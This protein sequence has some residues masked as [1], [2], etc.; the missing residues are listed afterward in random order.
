MFNSISLY[1]RAIFSVVEALGQ[2]PRALGPY[3]CLKMVGRVCYPPVAAVV[4]RVKHQL[5]LALT[6]KMAPLSRKRPKRAQNQ[7][8]KETG[9]YFQNQ[10][11]LSSLV[12]PKRFLNLIPPSKKKSCR[13]QKGKQRPQKGATLIKK[14]RAIIQ[15]QKLKVCMTI[16]RSFYEI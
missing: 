16:K 2:G 5:C 14:Y 7:T 1:S 12:G 8:K 11:C 10:C 3:R 6:P 15:K 13:A 4:N 9:L